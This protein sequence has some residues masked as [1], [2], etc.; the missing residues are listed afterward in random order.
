MNL[1]QKAASMMRP[2]WIN[3]AMLVKLLKRHGKKWLIE[4]LLLITVLFVVKT[5]LQRNL[6]DGTPPPLSGTFLTGQSVN[7]NTLKGKTYLLH[8]WASWCRVCRLEQDNIQ[9]ISEDYPV[10][11]VAMQS[12]DAVLVNEY[13]NENGLHFPVIIDE[14][15]A[16]SRRFGVQAVPVSYVINSKGRIAFAESGYTTEWGLRLRLWLAD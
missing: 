2:F 11:S 1:L 8:F 6:L 14:D 16:L 15:G 13:M 5:W 10:I 4:I 7:S 3:P 9:A 12:G